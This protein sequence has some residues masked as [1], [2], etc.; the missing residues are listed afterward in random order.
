MMPL[1][2]K[3]AD[4]INSFVNRCVAWIKNEITILSSPP[5]S[6]YQYIDYK[7]TVKPL[8]LGQTDL[9]KRYG[10]RSDSSECDV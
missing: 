2:I 1:E 6:Q 3:N 4:S 5:Q 8:I 10:S 9:S 7:I